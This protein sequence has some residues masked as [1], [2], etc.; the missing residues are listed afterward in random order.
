MNINKPDAGESQFELRKR[1]IE[2]GEN[3]R[4][5]AAVIENTEVSVHE[6]VPS[7]IYHPS[8][9]DDV[10]LYHPN[11][12][13]STDSFEI[14]QQ[15]GRPPRTLDTPVRP[16]IDILNEHMA[17]LNRLETAFKGF[18]TDLAKSYPALAGKPFGF[19]VGQD[20]GLVVVDGKALS[21]SELSLL[22]TRLNQSRNLVDTANRVAYLT[23]EMVES[24]EPGGIGKFHLDLKNFAQAIDLARA[25]GHGAKTGQ[26]RSD[27]RWGVQL[28]AKGDVRYG[29][30]VKIR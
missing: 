24:G 19:S 17:A 13:K 21:Q 9:H 27:A 5:T 8:Q 22:T 15:V 7:V 3:A 4:K 25:V 26:E 20:G 29:G 2:A 10:Y 16:L 6:V 23:I 18:F 14:H 30:W 11:A 1:V 12:L 28:E